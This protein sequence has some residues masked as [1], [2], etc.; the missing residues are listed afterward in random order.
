MNE[1]QGMGGRSRVEVDKEG[2][3]DICNSA[4]KKKVKKS[5]MASTYKCRANSASFRIFGRFM[6]TVMG[7]SS[8]VIYFSLHYHYV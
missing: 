5:S 8:S 2:K 7:N 4:N 3:G 6:K 1:G